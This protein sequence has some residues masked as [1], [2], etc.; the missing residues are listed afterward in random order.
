MIYLFIAIFILYITLSLIYELQLHQCEEC[1]KWVWNLKPTRIYEA[2]EEGNPIY[3][4]DVYWC[5]H[6][7]IYKGE[8]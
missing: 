6:C 3:A 8:E 5:N 7:K 1:K 2:D 4:G